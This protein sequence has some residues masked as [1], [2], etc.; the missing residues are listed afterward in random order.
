M[1]NPQCFVDGSMACCLY[2]CISTASVYRHSGLFVGSLSAVNSINNSF[3]YS[4][5]D[6]LET[7]RPN[8]SIT[9][10]PPTDETI[11]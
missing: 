6:L 1:N 5:I 9:E 8:E 7:S 10:V 11:R 4:S 3:V 2:L